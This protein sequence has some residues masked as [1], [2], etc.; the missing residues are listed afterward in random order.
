MSSSRR[1]ALHFQ[2]SLLQLA[3]SC[4]SNAVF[5]TQEHPDQRLQLTGEVYSIVLGRS[6]FV[7]LRSETGLQL[8][9]Q[10]LI[11]I[12]RD[13]TSQ[14]RA[15]NTTTIGYG[16][17]FRDA[18]GG[19]V[20]SF[21][22]HPDGTGFVRFPHL[23]VGTAMVA[24]DAPIRPRDFHRA[25]IPTQSVPIEDVIFFEITEL[26]VEPRRADWRAVLQEGAARRIAD[27]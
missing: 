8:A 25:H 12:D 24:A 19:E 13:R 3:I 11:R 27:V 1:D 17:R 26:A 2:R 23:H 21:H 5:I 15:W 10:H 20:V 4:I 14:T 16:Y 9:V 22:W 18:V 7:P 6:H